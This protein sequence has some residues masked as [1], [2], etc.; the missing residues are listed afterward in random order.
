MR[1]E[2]STTAVA[3]IIRRFFLILDDLVFV[4]HKYS[5]K[6]I[7]PAKKAP[8]ENVRSV[9]ARINAA[10]MRKPHLI[11]LDVCWS[12]KTSGNGKMTARNAAK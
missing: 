3:I 10:D 11:V 2:E 8:L 9:E 6:E 7:N 12:A 5:R 1:N 4:V